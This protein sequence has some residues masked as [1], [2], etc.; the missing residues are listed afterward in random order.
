MDKGSVKLEEGWLDLYKTCSLQREQFVYDE[1]P[2]F[3]HHF[4]ESLYKKILVKQNARQT[5]PTSK[6]EELINECADNA[7][8]RCR[9]KIKD[10]KSLKVV[11][12]VIRSK[13]EV[14]K[15]P[16]QQRLQVGH[17]RTIN[18][19]ISFPIF[20]LSTTEIHFL[21]TKFA[22]HVE[23]D[24]TNTKMVI[25]ANCYQQ[26][27]AELTALEAK[28][29]DVECK[30]VIP[31]VIAYL[32]EDPESDITWLHFNSNVIETIKE[33]V[34]TFFNGRKKGAASKHLDSK[35]VDDLFS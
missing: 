29:I 28:R 6:V 1:L 7:L 34:T 13:G 32:S 2:D 33:K 20:S 18:I 15:I 10:R 5:V 24:D 3:K 9:A 14:L 12:D 30:T 8:L 31:S 16:G 26:E 21:K 27:E 19:V 4:E 23:V 17:I 25:T 22:G 35:A 11:V